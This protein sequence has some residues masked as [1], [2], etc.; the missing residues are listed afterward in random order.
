MPHQLL[1]LAQA[2]AR[3]QI[4]ERELLHMAQRDEVPHQW[5]GEEPVFEKRLLDEWVQRRILTMGTAP[6]ATLQRKT[7][8]ELRTT[9]REDA[10]IKRLMRAEWINPS[11][12]A[13]TKPSLLREMAELAN[14]TSLLFDD[15]GFLDA[16]REREEEASTAI[17]GGIA[18]L[19]A[20]FHDPY[21][22]EDSFIVLG[23]T[24]P[25]IFFGG[26]EGETTDLFFLIYCTDDALH[27]HTLARLCMLAQT[28][29]LLDSL[30][31]AE[32][33]EE[34]YQILLE[35]EK[36]ILQNL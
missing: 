30:R 7:L 20:R 8:A 9:A 18:L 6:L 27:L 28:P 17:E 1:T 23:R 12:S 31:E 10:L 11:V 2:A 22:A 36:E 15:A 26:P 34:M 25:P 14:S 3:A 35:R 32:D 13:K 29:G 4:P 33:S 24:N 5:R 16:L 21:H 19:H